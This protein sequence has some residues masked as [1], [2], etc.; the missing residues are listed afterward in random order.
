[1]RDMPRLRRRTVTLALGLLLLGGT[2]AP[3][4]SPAAAA[5]PPAPGPNVVITG[6]GWGHSVGMSQ[7]GARAMAQA[8]IPARNILGHYYS[9]TTVRSDVGVGDEAEVAVD[10]FRN[11]VPAD[12]ARLFLRAKGRNGGTPTTHAGVR[13]G[14]PPG[15]ADFPL[16]TDSA[17]NISFDGAFVLRNAAGVELARASTMSTYVNPPAGDN[18]ALLALPQL[19]ATPD[20]ANRAGTYQHGSVTVTWDGTR[21]VPVLRQPMALYLRGIAEVPS[22]WETAALDAQAITARTYA[23]RRTGTVLS[24]T[25]TDQAYAGWAKEGE[26]V[27]GV[28]WVEAVSRTGGQ[29]VVA[30][31]GTLAQTFYSSSHGLGR[32]EASQDS[33]AYSSAFPYLL[34]V[35]DPWSM[36]AGNGNPYRSWRAEAGNPTFAAALGLARVNSVRILSRTPGRSPR[37]LSVDG[38]TTAGERITCTWSGGQA[39]PA[40][41]A[42][43]KGAGARLRGPTASPGLIART[44]RADGSPHPPSGLPSQQISSITLAPFTDD[45]DSVHQFNIGAVAAAG[46]TQGCTATTFC[47]KSTVTRGQMAAFLAR[48]LKLPAYTGPDRFSDIAGSPQR[49]EINALSAAGR[50][51]GYPDGSYRPSA[52]VSREQM[53]TFLARAFDVPATNGPDRF[54]DIAASVHRQKINDVAA[55]GLTSGCA[56]TTYCPSAPVS[57]EQMASF[58]AR[59]VGAGA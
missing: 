25:P 38:W 54:T 7:Y 57:R 22:S 20:P 8:G 37:V 9:G 39:C 52:A 28:R 3:G 35:E 30:P 1:M 18:P 2:A 46:I 17:Y 4:A 58:L 59:A 44:T 14:S 6:S 36:A 41:D 53:A 48:A 15:H 31:D 13:V 34:S 16:P 32:S 56:A 55:K 12:A 5:V 10:L 42:G 40:N 45:E 33:W 49:A 24:A 27:F 11:R 47:P 51:G 26:P 50:I 43:A 21:M 19:G 23:A 29:K